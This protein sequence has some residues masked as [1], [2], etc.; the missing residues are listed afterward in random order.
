MADTA[1]SRSAIV[2]TAPA[3]HPDAAAALADYDLHYSDG[4]AREADLIA[5]C[6]RVQPVAL[7]VRYGEV[8]AA[9]IDAAGPGLRVIAKHGVGIDNI[10]SA[11]AQ[12]RDIPVI[13]ALGSNSQAV[14]E[15][16][17][18]LMLACARRI[19][20]LNTRVHD[21]HWD[22][23]GYQGLELSGRTLGLVGIGSIG[24]RVVPMARAIGM[25]VVAYD[26]HADPERLPNGVTLRPL[27]ALVEE[28]DVVSL[29]CPL[30]PDTR[31]LLNA[32][33]LARLRPNAIVINAARAGLI[34]EPALVEALRAG[35]LWAAL[36]CFEDEPLPAG[37]LF[38]GVPNLILT[39][40]VGGTTTSAYRAMGLGAANNILA[41][42][43]MAP[44]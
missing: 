15:H 25:N 40:H 42:L 11:A 9:V 39:P 27:D 26:P 43:A 10:D 44:R 5:L 1:P 13:A 31:N 21:G 3:L 35:R 12:A 7:L 4:H 33:R 22:R 16:T 17:I 20:W 19:T 36:D 24:A 14:A 6:Q 18:G 38:H 23:D 2:V 41:T 29:H 32:E 28:A 34:D 37:S 8:S 30:T